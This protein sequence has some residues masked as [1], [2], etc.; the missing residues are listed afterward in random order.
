M[1]DVY[2]FMPEGTPVNIS[3][4]GTTASGTLTVKS[5]EARQATFKPIRIANLTSSTA[6]WRS[7][8]GAQSAVTTDLAMPAGSVEVFSIPSTHDTL[9]VI[10]SAGTGTV[11]V[12]HGYGV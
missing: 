11:Q 3:A 9:A 7:G 2:A 4:S 1:P 6:Y 10:L 12:Q 5:A 8:V